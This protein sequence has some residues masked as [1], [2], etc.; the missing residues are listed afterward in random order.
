M[1]L[2]KKGIKSKKLIY[3]SKKSHSRHCPIAISK[4][5]AGGRFSICKF[6]F[7]DHFYDTSNIQSKQN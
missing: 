6:V 5:A 7:Y 3:I 1:F 4:F 2:N